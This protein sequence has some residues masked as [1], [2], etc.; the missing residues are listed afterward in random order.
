MS[1]D[2]GPG[3]GDDGRSGDDD[4]VTSGLSLLRLVP[5]EVV[6]A[7]RSQLGLWGGDRAAAER[8]GRALV[9][10]QSLLPPESVTTPVL[11]GG[12]TPDE[13]IAWVPWGEDPPAASDRARP[14]G[15]WPGAVPGAAPALVFAPGRRAE[16]VDADGRPVTVSGRGE[17]SAAPV[18]LSSPVLPG[19]GG[20]VESWA[21]PWLSDLRWWDPAARRRRALW[22]IVAGG[23]A[24]L[25][26]VEGGE[27]HLEAIY[28]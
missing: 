14:P 4:L 19:G 20:T 2:A 26:A 21:G 25:V 12:R 1:R 15:L 6:V 7:G 16:L 17:A 18:R 11:Q 28:D 27:A 13:R 9:R 22:Q 23:V 24:C 10:L 8:A 3:R 5:E